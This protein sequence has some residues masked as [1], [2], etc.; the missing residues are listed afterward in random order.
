MLA[1]HGNEVYADMFARCY[2]TESIGLRY[3]NIFGPRQDP[4]GPY[5]AV[6]AQWFSAMI[7][8]DPLTIHGDG[9]SSR[10]FCFIANAVQANLLAA[11]CTD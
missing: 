6:I 9:D 2:Q 1:K 11:L 3:F 8:S 7:N 4:N 5:A 10:D